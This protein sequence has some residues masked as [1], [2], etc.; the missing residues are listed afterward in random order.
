[1]AVNRHLSFPGQLFQ[2]QHARGG[3]AEEANF[4]PIPAVT[5]C[6]ACRGPVSGEIRHGIAKPLTSRP[7]RG[8]VRPGPQN[9]P[10][11]RRQELPAA[12][13]A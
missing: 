5:A 1:M 6:R 2:V 11:Y 13:A 7:H 12:G 10:G 4:T 9:L 8:D 3:R